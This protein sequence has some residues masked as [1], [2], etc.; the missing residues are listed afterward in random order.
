MLLGNPSKRWH[1]PSQEHMGHDEME[2]CFPSPISVKKVTGKPFWS[3]TRGLQGHTARE[4]GQLLTEQMVTGA[5]F[6]S[7]F[8]GEAGGPCSTG[9]GLQKMKSTFPKQSSFH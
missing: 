1:F 8:P 9:P 7:P 2:T 3:S 4:T 5:M 6:I